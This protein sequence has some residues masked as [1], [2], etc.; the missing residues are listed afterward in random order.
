SN[1]TSPSGPRPARWVASRIAGPRPPPEGTGAATSRASAL[2]GPVYPS[3]P[4]SLERPFGVSHQRHRPP[5][6]SSDLGALG[7]SRSGETSVH[8]PSGSSQPPPVGR[9][10]LEET[11]EHNAMTSSCCLETEG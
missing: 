8:P 10:C 11:R 1:M 5:S 6:C 9:L 7:M 3:P 2:R 4:P